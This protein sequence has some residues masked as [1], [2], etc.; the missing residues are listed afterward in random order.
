MS[1]TR[2]AV[3]VISQ[4]DKTAT[5]QETIVEA[6]VRNVRESTLNMLILP[7][8]RTMMK[9]AS[10]RKALEPVSKVADNV[11]IDP[12]TTTIQATISRV[13]TSS[14][15]K[16]VTSS[17]AA[18]SRAVTSSASRVATSSAS[19]VATSPVSRVV[20][21]KVATSSV[22]ATSSAAATSRA[23]APTATTRTPN[24]I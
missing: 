14:A 10:V 5:I 8:E 3:K 24:T 1:R 6:H 20:T 22:A 11:S 16:A 7:N 21:S 4:Q 12:V 2:M 15:S 23:I 18:T 9:V 17:A 19:R 13:V